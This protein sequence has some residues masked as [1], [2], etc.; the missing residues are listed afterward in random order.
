MTN[1]YVNKKEHAQYV[2][3]TTMRTYVII[4]SQTVEAATWKTYAMRSVTSA[5]E[6]TT[7]QIARQQSILRH[8]FV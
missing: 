3:K 7:E 4:N 8:K 2:V 1:G 6:T 5:T